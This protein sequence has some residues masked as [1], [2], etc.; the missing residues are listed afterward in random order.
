MT[1][2]APMIRRVRISPVQFAV[3]SLVT[4]AAFAQTTPPASDK[5]DKN[6]LPIVTVTATKRATSLQETPATV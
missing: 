6:V 3:L 4:G 2:R 1:S 5:A